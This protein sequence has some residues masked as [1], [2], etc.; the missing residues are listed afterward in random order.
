[1]RL[2]MIPGIVCSLLLTSQTGSLLAQKGH[3]RAGGSAAGAGAVSGTA[4]AT[5]SAGNMRAAHTSASTRLTNNPALSKSIQPLLPSGMTA[6]AGSAGFRNQGQFIAALHVSKNLNIPFDQLKT[7]M[8]GDHAESLGRAIHD[9]RPSLSKSEVRKDVRVAQRQTGRDM[10]A[11]SLANRLSGNPAL[12]A[13]AQALLPAGTNVQTA[14]AGFRNVHEFLLAEHVARDLNIPFTQ[15]K[16]KVTGP[17]AV[18]LKQAIST[19]RPNLSSAAIKSDLKAARLET[20]ADLQAAGKSG[21]DR[22]Q[23]AQTR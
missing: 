19:L 6:A 21:D 16:A 5:T 18:S 13:R 17:D 9:L 23:I 4:P 7:R 20:R 14:A 12:S 22:N 2:S 15:L 1:M 11:A 8:T 3:G 10:D